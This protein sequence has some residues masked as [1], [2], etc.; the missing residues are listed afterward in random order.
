MRARLVTNK[1]LALAAGGFDTAFKKAILPE[2]VEAFSIN[3]F[4]LILPPM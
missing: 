4:P 3:I 1:L 2:L